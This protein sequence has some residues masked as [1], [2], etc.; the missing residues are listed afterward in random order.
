M[1]KTGNRLSGFF[2]KVGHLPDI[3]L[4]SHWSLI[5]SIVA[6]IIIGIAAI[7]PIN[8]NIMKYAGQDSGVFLY[9]G[10]KIL[11]GGVPYIDVW[12]HK[13][14][15]I[16]FVDALSLLITPASLVGIFIIQVIFLITSNILLYFLLR[17]YI[18]N[19]CDVVNYLCIQYL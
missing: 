19:S 8:P 14:P 2:P 7:Y 3:Q 6:C 10:T 16:Y 17:K 11:N 4:K 15:L 13:P 5:V 12:D 9:T 18:T 1:L